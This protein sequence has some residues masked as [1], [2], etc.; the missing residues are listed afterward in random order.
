[1]ENQKDSEEISGKLGYPNEKSNE[2]SVAKSYQLPNQE[3]KSLVKPL[4]IP[5]IKDFDLLENTYRKHELIV[6]FPN[7]TPSDDEIKEVKKSF[8]DLG[9]GQIR[10]IKCK[11]S[12]CNLPMQ[13]WLAENIHTIVSGT[14]VSAGTSSLHTV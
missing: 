10:V 9:I 6:I 7:N 13:L 11:C 14:V 4:I 8:H 12:G 3:K 1:M 5:S 2:S